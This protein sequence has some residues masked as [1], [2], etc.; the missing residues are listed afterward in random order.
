MTYTIQSAQWGNE[1]NTS[2]VIFTKEN[3][4]VAV[5][6]KDTPAEWANLLEFQKT[7]PTSPMPVFTTPASTKQQRLE[8][9]LGMT[10]SELKVL[11]NG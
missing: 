8:K 2:A 10:I 6:L 7:N 9:Q 4:A 11:L 5:S 3:G 1:D